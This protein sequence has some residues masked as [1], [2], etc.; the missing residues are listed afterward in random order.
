MHWFLGRPISSLIWCLTRKKTTRVCLPMHLLFNW[1]FSCAL[2]FWSNIFCFDLFCSNWKLLCLSK[3][4][5][6]IISGITLSHLMSLCFKIF[7]LLSCLLTFVNCGHLKNF[8][9]APWLKNLVEYSYL[10][11]KYNV[12][13]LRQKKWA[14]SFYFTFCKRGILHVSLWRMAL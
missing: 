7:L 6:T 9:T 14:F 12:K 3:W 2:C 8:V 1:I 13:I 4:I 10:L 5:F 11:P